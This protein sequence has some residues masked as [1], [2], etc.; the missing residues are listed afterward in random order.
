[1]P[2]FFSDRTRV[3]RSTTL[4]PQAPDARV[5][6]A[7]ADVM[8]IRPAVSNNLSKSDARP[9][10]TGERS[11]V[12]LAERP[13][14][15][16]RGERG[17][18]ILAS[19][20]SRAVQ[21]S[22]LSQAGFARLESPPLARNSEIEGLRVASGGLG[23]ASLDRKSETDKEACR[24]SAA[25]AVGGLRS[26]SPLG[27]RPSQPSKRVNICNRLGVAS[28]PNTSFVVRGRTSSSLQSAAA[29][30]SSARRPSSSRSAVTAALTA[31][32][33]LPTSVRLSSR[34]SLFTGADLWEASK[35]SIDEW[36]AATSRSSA[37]SLAR[38]TAIRSR[39]WHCFASARRNATTRSEGSNS[40]GALDRTCCGDPLQLRGAPCKSPFL[41][42]NSA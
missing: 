31:S 21:L 6:A 37:W 2:P 25:P 20:I 5:S 42:F 29:A 4:S 40:S 38:S 15:S 22:P 24:H 32:R 39:A 3:S 10:M 17:A 19:A 33:C 11:E 41:F 9:S 7:R 8:G 16:S 28:A 14:S 27:M 23:A 18:V 12:T 26:T 36:R 34:L 1:M 35:A 30:A 13:T